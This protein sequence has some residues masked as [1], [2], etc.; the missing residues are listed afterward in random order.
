MFGNF[1]LECL[2]HDT[3]IRKKGVQEAKLF[4]QLLDALLQPLVVAHQDLDALLGLARAQL[5]LLA[6]LAYRDVVAFAPPPV[7]VGAFVDVLQAV[8]LAGR[9]GANRT[10]RRRY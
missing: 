5:C 3:D 8:S 6:R 10:G 7:L 4:G 2:G 1:A 9:L